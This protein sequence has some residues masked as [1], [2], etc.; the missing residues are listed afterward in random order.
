MPF[1]ESK[2]VSYEYYM[3]YAIKQKNGFTLKC[4]VFWIM[5]LFYLLYKFSCVKKSVII[6]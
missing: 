3:Q 4:V 6:Y 1:K 2:I 5:S